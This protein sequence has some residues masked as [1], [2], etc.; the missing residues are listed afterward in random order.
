MNF[1]NL[2]QFLEFKT[3]ENE[4]KIRRTVSGRNR[5]VATVRG[6]A[7]CHARS[8]RRPAG[9]R[10]GGP[11]AR[12]P[13]TRWRLFAGQG[14]WR[15]GSQRRLGVDGAERRLDAAACGGVLAGGRV[16][17]GSG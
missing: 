2:K 15:R 10:T 9:P 7:A 12:S 13:V 11:V 16:T 1:G 14:E 4:L 17:D 3:I 8:A 5:P 6:P